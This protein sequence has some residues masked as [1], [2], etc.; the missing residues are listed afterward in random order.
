MTVSVCFADTGTEQLEAQQY[1]LKWAVSF[2]TN[3][4]K[5]NSVS[6]SALQCPLGVLVLNLNQGINNLIGG[7]IV[8]ELNFMEKEVEI[9]KK[10][11]LDWAYMFSN[12][13]ISQNALHKV[14]LNEKENLL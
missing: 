14:I 1:S 12:F 4:T 8:I 6:R 2:S 7:V 5:S 11:M 13:K 10:S 9:C 3:T